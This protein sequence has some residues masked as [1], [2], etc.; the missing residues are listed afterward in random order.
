MTVGTT[1]G[2]CT[3][4]DANNLGLCIAA[5]ACTSGY[6]LLGTTGL[7]YTSGTASATALFYSAA[8]AG[9]TACAQTYYPSSVTSG[10]I[11]TCSAISGVT[12]TVAMANA[13]TTSGYIPWCTVYNVA[14]AANT[15]NLCVAC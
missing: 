2:L 1:S 8:G 11:N 9:I 5:V 15:N 12:L 6:P 14:G 3:Q 13:A 4:A 10:V 7:C